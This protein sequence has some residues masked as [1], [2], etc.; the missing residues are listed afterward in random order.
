MSKIISIVGIVLIVAA[1]LLAAVSTKQEGV[2][3]AKKTLCAKYTK[4][5]EDA[6][7][8]SDYQ[9]AQKFAKL[10]IKAD[11]ENHSGYTMVAKIAQAQSGGSSAKAPATSAQPGKKKLTPAQQAELDSLGC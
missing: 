3:K 9:G 2:L 10:A 5:A 8:K 6:L 11:P 4:S 7:A 1:G